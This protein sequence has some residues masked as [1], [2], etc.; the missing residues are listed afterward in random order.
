MCAYAYM[1]DLERTGNLIE[2]V[3]WMLFGPALVVAVRKQDRS[4]KLLGLVACLISI[5]FG[6]SDL[7]EAQTGAW[8]RPW[9][10]FL[11]KAV[12]LTAL[13]VCIMAY[14]RIRSRPLASVENP[15]Q[16]ASSSM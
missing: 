16:A 6:I 1:V 3:F 11:W 7:V 14:R 9:W 5:L 2:A 13:G 15:P 12:C 10:L 8:W 4:V